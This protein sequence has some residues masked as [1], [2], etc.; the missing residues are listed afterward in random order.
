MER[1]SRRFGI[2]TIRNRIERKGEEYYLVKKDHKLFGEVF[3]P[4][5]T[6][7]VKGVLITIA[8][9]NQEAFSHVHQPQGVHE[10]KLPYTNVPVI[11]NIYL[12]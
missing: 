8:R 1:I 4:S 2:N 3:T 12:K 9:D 10:E 5:R 6:M 7:A 11:P